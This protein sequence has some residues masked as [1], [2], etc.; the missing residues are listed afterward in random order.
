MIYPA[1]IILFHLPKHP[2]LPA[3]SSVFLPVAKQIKVWLLTLEGIK[4]TR[5]FMINLSSRPGLKSESFESDSSLLVFC[6]FLRGR[7]FRLGAANMH[8]HMTEKAFL[9]AQKI[10]SNIYIIVLLF[11]YSFLKMG[12]LIWSS[13]MCSQTI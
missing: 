2:Y 5:G 4:L 11:Q 13:E 12:N 1:L 10:A 6:F 9:L 8:H 7:P 3:P